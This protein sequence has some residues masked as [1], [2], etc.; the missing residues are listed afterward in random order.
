M[1]KFNPEGKGYD[2]K[3]AIKAGMKPKGLGKTMS[4]NIT[5]HWGSVAPATSQEVKTNKLPQGS[6][7]LL[8]GAQ[9]PTTW[10]AILAEQQRGSRVIKH[11][12]KSK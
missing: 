3:S 6:Y 11:Q 9:H 8:K 2:Y 10:K 5:Q 4:A 12:G 7:K 1:T